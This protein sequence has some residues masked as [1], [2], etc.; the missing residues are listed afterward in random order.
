MRHAHRRVQQAQVVVDFSDGADGRARAAAGRLL[1]D[2][3][4]GAQ[5]VDAVDVGPLHLVEELPR[6]GRKRLDIAALALGVNG[7]EGER[8]F[9]RA[10]E[11]GDHGQGVARN[12]DVNVFQIVLA[13]PAD[14]DTG[15][16]HETIRFDTACRPPDSYI[17]AHGRVSPSPEFHPERLWSVRKRKNAVL[18]TYL[19]GQYRLESTR[20]KVAPSELW[21]GGVKTCLPSL[22]ALSALRKRSARLNNYDDFPAFN[23]APADDRSGVCFWRRGRILGHLRISKPV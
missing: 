6:V 16:A 22:P 1:L 9:A 2:G 17:S 21:L 19:S 4:R 3:D 23:H 13:C 14:A 8:G 12:L 10:A 18:L 20:G 7:V 15:N 5:P 11:A